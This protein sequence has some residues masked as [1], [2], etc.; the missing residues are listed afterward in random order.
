M[1]L[2]TEPEILDGLGQFL[3]HLGVGGAGW[4]VAG[5]GSGDLSLASLISWVPNYIVGP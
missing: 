5:C 1:K 4:D 3:G 2:F